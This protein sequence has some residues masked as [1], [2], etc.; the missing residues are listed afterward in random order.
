MG[1]IE[2]R[3]ARSPPPPLA[4]LLAL[5]AVIPVE[6]AQAQLRSACPSQMKSGSI[7]PR[8]AGPLHVTFMGATTLLFD[9]GTTQI[10]IDGF[11][12]RP[13]VSKALAGWLRPDDKRINFGLDQGGIDHRLQAIFVAHAHY[14]HAMDAPTIALRMRADLVG[15]ASVRNLGLGQDVPRDCTRLARHRVPHTYGRFTVTP[16]ET[17]HSLPEIFP[18]SITKPRPSPTWASHYRTGTS[19]SFLVEHGGVRI[20][21]YPTATVKRAR[22]DGIRADIVYLGT[23]G[24]ALKT[25]GFVRRYWNGVVRKVGARRVIP[26]HWDDMARPLDMGLRPAGFPTGTGTRNRALLACLAMQDGIEFED[27]RIF[28]PAVYGLSIEQL[29]P[30]RTAPLSCPN[31]SR[32]NAGRKVAPSPE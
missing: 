6:D 4:I 27:V 20:L 9:D 25:K 15:S 32:I 31:P 30:K 17:P 26:V 21:V 18:G 8:R 14:D 24:L 16:I 28:T 10:L 3:D 29:S 11:F 13:P 23:G 5:L 7:A 2:I 12:S 1:A 22:L 19:F